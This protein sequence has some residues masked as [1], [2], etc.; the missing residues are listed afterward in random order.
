M[1]PFRLDFSTFGREAHHAGVPPG[2]ELEPSALALL[3]PPGAQTP[4]PQATA[5]L[6][7][8]LASLPRVFFPGLRILSLCGFLLLL[9]SIQGSLQISLRVTF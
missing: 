8:G 5:Q 2:M 9:Q 3:C 1:W 4:G 7:E 6:S